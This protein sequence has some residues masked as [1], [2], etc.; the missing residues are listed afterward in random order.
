MTDLVKLRAANEAR[1][2]V[3]RVTGAVTSIDAAARRLV[4]ADAKMRYAHL[5]QAT[6]VP[7]PVIA[8]IH[9]REASQSWSRS[10]AQGDSWDRVSTHVPKGR[11]PFKSWHDAG[12]DALVN[13]APYAAHNH[14]WSAGGALTLLE[15]YNGLGYANKGIPSPYIW[16]ST[17]QYH[18]G[19]YV[20]DG[21][22]DPNAVD[23]Q[24]GC[25]ALLKRMALLDA[26]VGFGDQPAASA[27]VSAPQPVAKPPHKKVAAAVA[28]AIPAAAAAHTGLPAGDFVAAA[29][30]IAAVVIAV[31]FFR[32]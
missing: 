13:C 30:V 1:W 32:K 10:I 29:I 4:S 12:V 15:A 14:D 28:V 11:G 27:P 25:A 3:A 16:A 31:I 2:K 23:K 5:S 17:D 20:A 7:W 26:S 9:E 19:K 18:S 6:G 24:I 21:V 22:F 8:V